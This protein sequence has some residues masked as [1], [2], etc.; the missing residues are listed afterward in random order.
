MALYIPAGDATT[1]M[2]AMLIIAFTWFGAPAIV[3]SI[4]KA[5][6]GYVMPAWIATYLS[7]ILEGVLNPY[8]ITALMM[9]QAISIFGTARQNWNSFRT[10]V[11]AE[12]ELAKNSAFQEGLA[13]KV[14]KSSRRRSSTR[15]STA[16][17]RSPSPPSARS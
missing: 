2:T 15:S 9:I 14:S 12:H 11:A 17:R 10:R 4:P 5:V 13:R 6:T 1:Q 16:S 3:S 7:F 8:L